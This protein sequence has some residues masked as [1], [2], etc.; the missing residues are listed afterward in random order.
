M[1]RDIKMGLGWCYCVIFYVV[2]FCQELFKTAEIR[3][4]GGSELLEN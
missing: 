2:V 1:S 3:F 4:C